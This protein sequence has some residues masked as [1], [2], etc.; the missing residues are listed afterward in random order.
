M[1]DLI[2]KL[3]RETLDEIREKP[4]FGKGQFHHVYQSKKYPNRLFKIGN[5]ETVD[6]WIS[7]FREYPKYFPKVYRS[8]PYIKDPSLIVVEIEKLDT[9]RAERELSD[10]D[11]FLFDEAGGM[12]CNDGF[13]TILDFFEVDCYE[14]LKDTA[15]EYNKNF[16]IIL[17]KWV[18]FLQEVAPII[19]MQLGRDLDLHVGNVAYDAQGNLKLIDI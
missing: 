4:L 14:I 5:E 10:I 6:E 9:K 8:F 12:E 1:K 19:K 7:T 3:L 18:K 13:I 17:D 2:K 16:A 11:E 15:Y